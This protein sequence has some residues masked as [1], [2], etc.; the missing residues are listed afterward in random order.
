MKRIFTDGKYQALFAILVLG[1]VLRFWGLGNNPFVADEF[2]D[3]NSS[4][5]YFQTGEWKAWDFNDGKPAVVNGNDARDE[6]AS[7]YKWQVAQLFRFLPPTE[8]AARTVS[9]VWGVLT[10]LLVFLAGW[11]F[12]GRRTV[13]LFAAFLFAVS[14]SGLEFD[15]R[16]R[17]YSMFLPV[18]LAFSTLLYLFYEREYKGK[19]RPVRAVRER[20]GLNLAYL[21]PMLVFGV[22]SA[23]THQLTANIVPVFGAYVLVMAVLAWRKGEGVRNRYGVTVAFGIFGV[24]VAFVAVPEKV[25][26]ALGT[27]VFFDNHYSYLGYVVRDYTQP[28]LAIALAVLGAWSLA[29]RSGKG[30]EAIWLSVSFLV[31]LVMAVWFWRRNEGEQYIFFALPFLMILVAA[32]GYEVVRFVKESLG[33]RWKYAA[34]A[35]VVALAVFVPRWEYFFQENNTYHRTNT[36]S[37][38]N[39]RKVFAYV[40]KHAIEGDA[41]V[42][43]NFRNYYWSGMRLPV[44]DFG[45]ELSTTKLSIEEL[46]NLMAKYP[47]GWVVMS[48]NDTDYVSRAAE[49]FMY[50]N[51]V[52]ESDPLLRGDVL[53]FRWGTESEGA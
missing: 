49:D 14:V 35:A 41:L 51:M 25:R 31:P 27:L 24:A 20:T 40:R 46:S 18:F 47:S 26:Y 2:L 45:G 13:G 34:C 37:T 28:V 19:L 52:R 15:R 3:I 7:V 44:Y 5:G 22:L 36:A 17:M 42:T 10:V 23:M 43:R 16:L 32:G 33:A 4:Y 1:A 48:D 11:I 38:A 30:R 29:K 9:A 39:Y 50:R 21:V 53:V 12:S 8:A 6:R